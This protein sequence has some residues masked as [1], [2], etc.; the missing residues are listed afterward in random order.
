MDKICKEKVKKKDKWGSIQYKQASNTCSSEIQKSNQGWI[1]P[2]SLQRGSGAT[3]KVTSH[4]TELVLG[5]VTIFGWV[6]YLGM[7]EPPRPTQPPDLSGIENEY[8]PMCS[9]VLGCE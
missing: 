9:D 6:K 2:R 4:S 1:T 8:Q 3:Y 7:Y 5:E